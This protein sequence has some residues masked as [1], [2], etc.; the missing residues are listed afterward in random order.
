MRI[1]VYGATGS[2]G[3]GL[4]TEA[5]SRGH[6]V[7]GI[8]RRESQLS[9]LPQGVIGRVGDAI[10]PEEI[11][12]VSRDQDVVIGATRPPTGSERDLVKTA[13]ALLA[14]T[15][16]TGTRLLLVG[17]AARLKIPETG[18]LVVDDPRFVPPSVRKIALACNA[19][20][21]ACLA[22][23][24]A[25]WTYV[26]PPALLVPGERTG[27]YRLGTDT[28]RFNADGQSTISIEDFAVAIIDEAEAPRHRGMGFTVAGP[29]FEV[30]GND[31]LVE[32]PDGSA[33]CYF[34]HPARGA[35]AGIILWPDIL[36]LRPAM[37]TAADRLAGAG[38]SVVVI[39]P[40]YRQSRAP[41]GIDAEEFGEPKGRA[42]AMALA[43]AITPDMTR[44]DAQA[45]ISF[46]NRQ[47]PV[48]G[49]R[50]LGAVGYCLGAAMAIRCAAS[51]PGR[52]GALISL[53]GSGLVTQKSASPHSLIPAT[54]ARALFA[55]AE[56]GDD[57]DPAVKRVLYETYA[58]AGLQAD[59]E[60]FPGTRHGW[61]ALDTKSY[62][63]SCAERAWSRARV[64][65]RQAII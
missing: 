49:T 1:A 64:L 59:F 63:R 62:D 20:Y 25:E 65:L 32:T 42:K 57:R 26:S 33:D 61:C 31:V 9:L 21:E 43:G 53:H 7:T 38:Y 41:I 27:D 8:V 19:Q 47:P 50:K 22:D 51:A 36:G 48:D 56:Q 6:A 55:I 13:E 10:D 17:G 14:G 2:I 54:C 16:R 5:L 30:T 44:M 35:H 58:T 46:L 39:N 23:D 60:V 4:V 15:A 29:V 34:V 12:T 28:L 18:G 11:A 52:I 37:R 24:A 3:T 40:Y 45:V